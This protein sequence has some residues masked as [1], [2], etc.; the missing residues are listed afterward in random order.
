MDSPHFDSAFD[1][2][3]GSSGGGGGANIL[4]SLDPVTGDLFGV[5]APTT[6]TT[7]TT[8]SSSSTVTNASQSNATPSFLGTIKVDPGP[9]LGQA[10]STPSGSSSSTLTTS[11]LSKT[12]KKSS[13]TSPALFATKSVPIPTTLNQRE[14]PSISS[15]G[16]TPIVPQTSAAGPIVRAVSNPL[17]SSTTSGAVVTSMPQINLGGFVGG[18]QPT[19]TS[20]SGATG[21]LQAVQPLITSST[22]SQ[23]PM[24][25]LQ[26]QPG[27]GVPTSRMVS[28]A[29]T[30]G[31]AAKQQ[32]Q[33][34]PKPIGAKVATNRQSITTSVP[35]HNVVTSS[36]AVAVT[37]SMPV[38]VP[39]L[40]FSQNNV[41]TTGQQTAAPLL[42]NSMGQVVGQAQQQAPA[43]QS[44]L[45]QQPS[46]AG[47]QPLLLM[48]PQATTAPATIL[49]AQGQPAPILLQQPAEM[50]GPFTSQTKLNIT[51]PQGR[52]QM[53]QIQTPTGTKLVAVPV[54]QTLQMQPQ[55]LQTQIQ[56]I[57]QPAAQ[58]STTTGQLT[59]LP[60]QFSAATLPPGL[61]LGT[62]AGLSLATASPIQLSNLPTVIASSSAASAVST[63]NL[64]ETHTV[65]TAIPT[66]TSSTPVS[67]SSS[68]SSSGSSKK[69]KSKKGKR[70]KDAANAALASAVAAADAAA[71]AAAA[72]SSSNNGGRKQGLDLGELMKD[73][74]LDLDGFGMEETGTA[75]P[76][77]GTQ[78]NSGMGMLGI[79]ASGVLE[80]QQLQTAS[81]PI[82]PAL[83]GSSGSQL[84]AQIQQP[85]P[86]QVCPKI[87]SKLFFLLRMTVF[88]TLFFSAYDRQCDAACSWT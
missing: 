64:S 48:R 11:D 7:P 65:V 55:Q 51:T 37:M 45:I 10:S 28:V 88:S 76:F 75:D 14:Q 16:V 71:V 22:L 72:A 83:P 58:F 47:Q 43:Q 50:T 52:M 57:A 30:V 84:V 4:G 41:L 12:N 1:G 21:Q 74:G 23:Q 46:V 5:P 36:A 81:L 3:E 49:P 32:P 31:S 39:S 53:Q 38:S 40:I 29:T 77:V 19:F 79:S 20:A 70:D 34:L 15:L 18:Q 82:T 13:P 26:L 60:S 87:K 2:G 66:T 80:P 35:Q 68:S 78:D 6:S 73:V 85:L 9:M 59:S 54:G 67:T 25:Q 63:T 62:T 56:T 27:G 8:A 69:K 17:S 86:L 33:L 24:I 44:F 61:H 42:F